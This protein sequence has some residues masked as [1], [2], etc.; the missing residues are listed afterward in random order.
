[1][2]VKRGARE[3]ACTVSAAPPG[4][5]RALSLHSGTPR[6]LARSA[7]LVTTTA[8]YSVRNSQCR[9]RRMR[10]Q[11]L[12]FGSS[13]GNLDQARLDIEA[14]HR[15]VAKLRSAEASAPVRVNAAAVLDASR[16]EP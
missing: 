5:E 9:L 7:P 6:S 4:P 13:A 1:M 2:E 11:L 8:R 10:W 16:R 12:R 15:G 14:G 3:R